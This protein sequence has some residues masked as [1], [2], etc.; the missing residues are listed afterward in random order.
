M[1]FLRMDNPGKKELAACVKEAELVSSKKVRGK[2]QHSIKIIS[3]RVKGR[4][5]PLFLSNSIFLLIFFIFG[6]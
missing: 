5:D 2:R 4:P 6:I 3:L 1:A